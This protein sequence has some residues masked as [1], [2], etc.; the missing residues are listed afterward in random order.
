MEDLVFTSDLGFEGS[1]EVTF[2]SQL[3]GSN[4]GSWS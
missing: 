2:L 1:Q 4:M 3:P